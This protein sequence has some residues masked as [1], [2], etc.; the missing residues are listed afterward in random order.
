MRKFH[1]SVTGLVLLG[2]LIAGGCVSYDEKPVEWAAVSASVAER[3]PGTLTFEGALVYAR[4]HNPELKR[5]RAE[6]QAAGLDVP[7]TY[8][9]LSGNSAESKALGF[10]D[11]VALFKLGPRGA[12]ARAA[13][14]REIAMLA[15][16]RARDLE[17]AAGIAET[18]L[19]E[20]VLAETAMPA[21]DADPG[22]F[23]RAGLASPTERARVTY[24][25][26][27]ERA[28]RFT[29]VALRVENAARLRMLL[30]VGPQ[31]RL[32]IVTPE[33]R[34]FPPLPQARDV[35]ARPDLA[36]AL[37]RY[38]VADAEFRAA[39]YD[40]YPTFGLGPVYNWNLLRWGL[41]LPMRIPVGAA[42]PARAAGLRREAARL[43][44]EEVLIAAQQDAV[45]SR[46]RF[47][48]T[49]AQDTAARTGADAAAMDLRFALV[50]LEV[51]PD[52]FGHL[53]KAAPEA[54][55]RMARARTALAQAYA[56]PHTEVVR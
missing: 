26:Q 2:M 50:H 29:V 4:A 19:V 27:K 24:A 42:G 46:A 55:E 20:R 53:A 18:Y 10:V 56:W 33:E 7:P 11:P 41:L 43:K 36:V 37:A 52:A 3:H 30:G 39:V 16:L 8:V 13:H 40:Q 32:E 28:E 9:N 5:L 31:A 21:V 38:T 22:M 34:E 23:E 15:E 45:A 12:R 25:R 6:A 35:M 54:V 48:W 17:V 51:T 47:D 14:D 1:L 44:V 49:A